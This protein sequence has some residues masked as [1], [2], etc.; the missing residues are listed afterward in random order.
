MEGLPAVRNLQGFL[1]WSFPSWN[2]GVESENS[3][4][5]KGGQRLVGTMSSTSHSHHSIPQNVQ[6]DYFRGSVG[7]FRFHPT[8]KHPPGKLLQHETVE[9]SSCGR[10]LNSSA[11]VGWPVWTGD[12]NAPPERQQRSQGCERLRLIPSRL[13]ARNLAISTYWSWWK[14]EIPRPNQPPV[15]WCIKPCNIMG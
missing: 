1:C 11:Q 8:S 13:G 3:T 6:T 2:H 5:R 10:G 12:P 4:L 7:H 15:G 14:K 9:T